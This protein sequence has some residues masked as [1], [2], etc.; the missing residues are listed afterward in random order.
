MDDTSTPANALPAISRQL[1]D[2]CERIESLQGGGL[3]DLLDDEEDEVTDDVG[4]SIVLKSPRSSASRKA[5]LAASSRESTKP[6]ARPHPFRLVAAGL[7]VASVRQER[8]RQV[9]VWRGRR[10]AVQLQADRQNLHR[11]HRVVPQGD[12]HTEPESH[13]DRPPYAHQR[14]TF[15]DMCEMEHNPVL[16]GT[17]NASA[18]QTA[19]KE[20]TFT[21]GSRIM[22]GARENGFGRAFAERGRGRVR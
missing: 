20:I 5:S 22:F 2:V 3:T 17:W 21:S 15:A 18:E 9:C 8:G 16:G 19:N 1:I 6:R 11:R 7:L 10:R 14:Q 12:T 13:L 4:A